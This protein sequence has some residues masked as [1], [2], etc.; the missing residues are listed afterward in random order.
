MNSSNIVLPDSVDLLASGCH[1]IVEM[2][3]ILE[4]FIG[5]KGS[6]FQPF[7][8]FQKMLKIHTVDEL[9]ALQLGAS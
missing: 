8:E 2:L 3:I 1:A 7:S 5:W 9:S 6:N 4:E